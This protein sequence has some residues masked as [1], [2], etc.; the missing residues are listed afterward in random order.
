M[1]RVYMQK[2]NKEKGQAVK[3]IDRKERQ[4]IKRY[5]EELRRIKEEQEK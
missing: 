3:E 4:L 1:I 5:E 2:N